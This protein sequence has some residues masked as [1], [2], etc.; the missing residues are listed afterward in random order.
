MIAGDSITA[1][2]PVHNGADLLEKLLTSA[3]AQT[4]G[5]REVIVIDNASNDNAVAV[6][7]RFG[8]RVLQLDRNTGFASAVNLGWQSAV[9]DWVAI[10]NSDVELDREWVERLASLAESASFAAGTLLSSGNPS[11]MDGSYDLVSRGGCAWRAGHGH[12]FS[13]PGGPTP[14]A[15]A[16]ATACL[17]RRDVLKSLGGFDETFGSY[18]EDVELGMRC[19]RSGFRG[20]YVPDAIARHQG[21]ATYGRWNP[22]V[23][24]LISRNQL[25]IIQRHYD[26]ALFRA[27]LWPILIGQILWGLLALKHGAFGAWWLG[28]R[29]GLREFSAGGTACAAIHDFLIASES[30]IR[31][32]ATGD[33]YWRWYFRLTAAAH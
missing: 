30:E 15:V 25:L 1:V 6:A 22:T 17:F 16:P 4:V 32:R 13:T 31:A 29:E 5:F 3:R 14:I 11:V 10:L 12:T 9:S 24:R 7:R 26:P 28:K 20:I 33:F 2:V 8:C 23:V 19:I 27:C 21:S 18:L